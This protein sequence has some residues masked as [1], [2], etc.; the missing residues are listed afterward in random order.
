MVSLEFM[1]IWKNIV[2]DFTS[3]STATRHLHPWLSC[4]WSVMSKTLYNVITLVSL[5]SLLHCAYSAAQH[6]SYLRLT[7]QPFVT[8]P[9]DVLAQTLISLVALIYGASHVAG[10]FQHIKSDP[11][12]RSR[13]HDNY[14]ALL[15]MPKSCQPELAALLAFNVEL[16]LVREK[17]TQRTADA[18]GMYRLQFWRDAI[19]AIYGDSSAPIP[20]QLENYGVAT[21]GA[22]I[23]LQAD[24]LARATSVGNLTE[25]VIKAADELGAAYGVMNLIRSSLPLLLKGVVLLPEDLMTIHNLTPDIVYKRKNPEALVLL[26][27]DLVKFN[28]DL[29]DSRLQRRH[30]FLMWTL[31][32]KNMMGRADVEGE[33]WN[34]EDFLKLNKNVRKMTYF[35]LAISVD[36]TDSSDS[37]FAC[38]K[39]GMNTAHTPAKQKKKENAGQSCCELEQKDR[40]IHYKKKGVKK[41]VVRADNTAV[42][43]SYENLV[44]R[45]AEG[46]QMLNYTTTITTED[47]PSENVLVS[48][49][50]LLEK[51]L[52]PEPNTSHGLLILEAG[53]TSYIE[54]W[55]SSAQSAVKLTS[56]RETNPP[57]VQEAF[58]RGLPIYRFSAS[59]YEGVPNEVV[60]VAP[61]AYLTSIA[62]ELFGTSCHHSA[63]V[64]APLRWTSEV[65]Q[66]FVNQ[67]NT[68]QVK[69]CEIC[70][71][72]PMS[73]EFIRLCP[74]LPATNSCVLD[75]ESGSQYSLSAPEIINKTLKLSFLRELPPANYYLSCVINC[76]DHKCT[77][78]SKYGQKLV[79]M[80]YSAL[81]ETENGSVVLPCEGSSVMAAT[82]QHILAKSQV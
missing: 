48:L 22:L 38:K 9:A 82:M 77:I 25:S 1:N 36:V 37:R 17:I 62:K 16:A 74:Q 34:G 35:M 81:I 76:I 13:D 51:L 67:F 44:S 29:Y 32:F 61:G 75:S 45:Y 58:V 52:V 8:L 26:V 64:A 69:D 6:H 41:A 10:A 40:N 54:W 71:R 60:I 27:K 18:T 21:T 65:A 59:V 68:I 30:P 57:L 50:S 2:L 11:A 53:N 4:L 33:I 3:S 15:T 55:L 31:L 19:A 80:N 42:D 78:K 5:L 39:L 24:T 66:A 70:T 12:V 49:D 7:E 73:S 63:L 47:L 46:P 79:G 20:R 14:Q 56:S 72:L 43:D 28:Y 23:R